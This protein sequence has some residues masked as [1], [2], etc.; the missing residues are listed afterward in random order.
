MYFLLRDN[1]KS[2]PY[3]LEDLKI[4]GI[5]STDMLWIESKSTSWKYPDEIEEIQSFVNL[6]PRYAGNN[7]SNTTLDF[8]IKNSA[9]DKYRND[10]NQSINTSSE[11]VINVIIADDHALFRE[12]V[13]VALSH[14]KDIKIIGEADNGLRLLDLLKHSKAD[15]VLLDIQ[16]PLMDGIT[17]LTAIRKLNKDLKIIMLSMHNGSSMVS[18]LMA[19]GANAYL[20]KTADSESIYEAIRNCYDKSYY[21]NELTNISMLEKIRSGGKVEDVNT[22]PEIKEFVAPKPRE[23][24]TEILHKEPAK[25]RKLIMAI[26]GFALLIGG[27]IAASA[28]FFHSS[29]NTLNQNKKIAQDTLRNIEVVNTIAPPVKI[30]D[31]N[32]ALKDSVALKN[33]DTNNI[34][35]AKLA[36][37]NADSSLNKKNS[38]IEDA[39]NNINP[40]SKDKT[41]INKE[42][43]TASKIDNAKKLNV[44]DTK[45]Q[46]LITKPDVVIKKDSVIRKQEIVA[47]LSDYLTK[48]RDNIFS[49]VKLTAFEGKA[50]S[51]DGE[52]FTQLKINNKSTVKI[53]S[54]MVEVRYFSAD[55]T[56]S[57]SDNIVFRNIGAFSSSV[58]QTHVYSKGETIKSAIVFIKSKELNLN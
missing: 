13:K 25:N 5:K 49:L 40:E 20:S 29:P 14:K 28:F 23:V 22:T 37:I 55:S 6:L 56:L 39:K 15:V 52:L 7:S 27:G 58:K 11:K 26:V 17:A 9:E 3:S 31:T 10:N 57:K 33:A 35:K 12:G 42:N 4:K 30:A 24:V 34:E 18:L 45:S 51:T 47:P 19:T 48:V 41:I 8:Q 21:F 46:A 32:K 53:D 1:K 38:K 44:D 50:E 43:E 54:V 36:L 16:M 2:G